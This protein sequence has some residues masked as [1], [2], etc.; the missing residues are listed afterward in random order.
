MAKPSKAKKAEYNRREYL[1]RCG[2]DY[3]VQPP[4]S[5]RQRFEAFVDRAPGHGPHGTCWVWTGARDARGYGIF[6]LGGRS[7]VRRASR[8]ALSWNLGRPL[9]E[10]EQACHGCDNPPC[11]RV[12][13]GHIFLGD[14]FANMR[15]C[16]A[17]G[18][19][20]SVTSPHALARGDRNGAR[21]HPERMPRGARHWTATQPERLSSGENHYRAK[22]TAA[23]VAAIR[24]QCGQGRSKTSLAREFGVAR[25]TIGDLV[26]GKSWKRLTAPSDATLAPEASRSDTP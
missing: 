13:S 1:K 10:E 2:R 19:H 18:R 20:M 5:P 12:G 21:K 8:I 16:V 17:K 4:R 23:Q 6:S 7:K 14:Q 22:L 3:L 9:T 11:V 15:D 26:S 24:E 25:S